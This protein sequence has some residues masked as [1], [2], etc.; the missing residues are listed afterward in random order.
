MTTP[1]LPDDPADESTDGGPPAEGTTG[2][3]GDPDRGTPDRE[4]PDRDDRNTSAPDHD[5]RSADDLSADDLDAR[6]LA[7]VSGIAPT[8]TWHSVPSDTALDGPRAEAGPDDRGSAPLRTGGP[9]ADDAD[10][11]GNLLDR[12]EDVTP[13]VGPTRFPP[14]RPTPSV[15]RTPD[16]ADERSRR[17]EARR[18]ERAEELAAFHA[19]KAEREREYAEDDAHYEPPPP[20]PLPRPRGRTVA[21]V[22]AIAAGVLL[23]A[24]PTLLELNQ[25]V[26]IV[27]AVLIILG[28]LGVLVAGLHRPAADG[29]DGWDDGARL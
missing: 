29:S 10:R 24:R 15:D 12:P 2:P 4:A 16:T 21:A 19:E 22:L 26:S 1:H 20:P 3:D 14:P 27:L 6:F 7:I 11:P 25:D 5:D 13:P 18:Q 23:L 8:M 17:R 28:G 9:D